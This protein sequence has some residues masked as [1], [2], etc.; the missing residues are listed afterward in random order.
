MSA[1]AV[2]EL[3][4]LF[5]MGSSPA[6]VQCDHVFAIFPTMLVPGQVT[7]PL[8]DPRLSIFIYLVVSHELRRVSENFWVLDL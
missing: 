2:K 1:D 4:I 5:V 3:F 8:Y 7:D 6:Q